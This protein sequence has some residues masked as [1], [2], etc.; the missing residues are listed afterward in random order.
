M[1]IADTLSDL[2]SGLAEAFTNALGSVA[3][4]FFTNGAD[5]FKLEP[6]GYIAL[7]GLALSIVYFAIKLVTGLIKVKK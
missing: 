7:I 2:V 5:G 1:T 6:L 4:I 3:S